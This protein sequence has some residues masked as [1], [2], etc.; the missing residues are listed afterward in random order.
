MNTGYSVGLLRRWIALYTR[1]LPDEVRA[2]RRDE[3]DGDIWSHHEEAA[4]L[5][6]PAATV[7]REILTRLVLGVPAD[8]GWRLEQAGIAGTRAVSDRSATTTSRVVALLAILGGA[9]WSTW[10]VMLAVTDAP[11]WSAGSPSSVVLTISGSIGTLALAGA[12]Y[13]LVFSNQERI[14]NGAAFLG[15]VGA[16]AG[17]GSLVGLY[18]GAAVLPVGSAGVVWELGRVGVLLKWLSWAHAAA[19]ALALIP[20][21]AILAN[22]KILYDRGSVLL[23][24][25]VL[26]YAATWIA[27]GWSLRHGLPVVERHSEGV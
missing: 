16:A 1:G 18:V 23:M 20:I 2:A 7:S 24:A 14:R 12:T 8:I 27:I 25:L 26:P 3:I 4:R 22:Y 9:G 13:G 11:F 19:A 17:A 21:V 15:S 6:L 10:P 5:G